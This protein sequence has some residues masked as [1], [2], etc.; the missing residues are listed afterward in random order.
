MEALIKKCKCGVFLTVNEYRDYYQSVTDWLNEQTEKG[1]QLDD[2][3]L[4]ERMIKEKMVYV[5]QFYPDTPIVSYTVYGTTLD[6]VI[7]KA[8]KCFE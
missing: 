4:A 8:N 7:Y 3:K 6:E 5:L 1:N 2:S